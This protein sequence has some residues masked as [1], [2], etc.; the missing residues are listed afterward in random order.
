MIVTRI[1]RVFKLTSETGAD[2]VLDDPNPSLTPSE[3]MK[4]YSGSYPELTNSTISGPVIEE[5]QSVYTFGKSVG[6]KG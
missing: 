5:D 1:E 6:K 2:I 4:L 3:V